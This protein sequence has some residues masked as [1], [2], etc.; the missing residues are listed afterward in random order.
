[1]KQA[2][3]RT[4]NA[5]FLL[6]DLRILEFLYRLIN[7]LILDSG[8][9]ETLRYTEPATIVHQEFVAQ[10]KEEFG[11]DATIHAQLH[12]VFYFEREWYVVRNIL[13]QLEPFHPVLVQWIRL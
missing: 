8:Y 10:F 5:C 9:F 1:M 3:N 6:L 11:F 13:H 12:D 7:H 4:L 2:L